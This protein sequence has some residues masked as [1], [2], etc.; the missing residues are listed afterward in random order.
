MFWYVV[1]VVGQPARYAGPDPDAAVSALASSGVEGG[2]EGFV[3][4]EQGGV[5][6]PAES[7]RVEGLA[8]AA[9]AE[10]DACAAQWA[11]ESAARECIP[12]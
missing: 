10:F 8:I 7:G 11:A 4:A 9:R 2:E 5:Y 1:E 6:S 12:S 3:V